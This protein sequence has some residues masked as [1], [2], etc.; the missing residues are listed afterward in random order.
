M[1]KLLKNILNGQL[2]Y[3]YLHLCHAYMDMNEY[4]RIRESTFNK[5]LSQGLIFSHVVHTNLTATER[6]HVYSQSCLQ[7]PVP[8]TLFLMACL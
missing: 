7:S 6:N 5:F 8:C 1:P 3:L 4:E 2:G